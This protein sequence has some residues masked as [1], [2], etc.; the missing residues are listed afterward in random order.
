MPI[1]Q[2]NPTAVKPNYTSGTASQ[3]EWKHERTDVGIFPLEI[4]AANSR[5]N[6]P[7]HLH[8]QDTEPE[9]DFP[10]E[11][12]VTTDVQHTN[13]MY[14]HIPDGGADIKL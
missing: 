2:H 5:H 8:T 3:P 11:M 6:N 1:Q 9:G 13:P 14:A 4:T 7:I 12:A 10:S